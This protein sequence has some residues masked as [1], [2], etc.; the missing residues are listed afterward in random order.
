MAKTGT[1]TGGLDLSFVQDPNYESTN[2]K[3]THQ[4]KQAI[5]ARNALRLLMGGWPSSINPFLSSEVFSAVFILRNPNLLKEFRLAF[6]QGF[7]FLHQQLQNNPPLTADQQEQVQLYLS[8]CLSLLPY[9]DLTPWETIAMPQWIDGHWDLVLYQVEPIELTSQ[10]NPQGFFFKVLD[11]V[12]PWAKRFFTKDQDRVFAYG[13]KP[14]INTKAQ[15]HLIFMGTTYPVGQGFIRHIDT[16]LKG[17]ES[18][19]TSLYQQSRKRISHW[20]SQQNGKVHVCG[21]SLGGALSLLLAIDQ[22]EHIE[23][24]D[25]LNPPGLHDTWYKNSLDKWDTIEDKPKVVV[26]KQ[27]A[28]PVS[29]FGIWKKEWTVLAVQ[30]PKSK[31]GPNGF[32]DHALNYAGFANTQFTYVNAAD[33]NAKRGSR[34]FWIFSLGRALVYYTII[35]PYLY[36]IRPILYFHYEHRGSFALGIVAV[37]LITIALG[38]FSGGM[39][40]AS[41]ILGYALGLV[42]ESIYHAWSRFGRKHDETV[43]ALTPAEV[44][45]ITTLHHPEQPRNEEMDVYQSANE[46]EIELTTEQIQSYYKTMRTLK[47]KDYL[48]KHDQPSKHVIGYNKKDLLQQIEDK[49]LNGTIRFK[50]TPAKVMH[51]V[52]TLGFVAQIGNAARAKEQAPQEDVI[53]SLKHYRLGKH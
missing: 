1:F 40:P 43:G 52:Q 31:Q 33:D 29:F 9:A 24:V 32:V 50:A 38:A 25:A 13:L 30:P 45:S 26:Q 36:L 14:I 37:V 3:H 17:L 39:I 8:N 22:G 7:T 44:E 18:V 48:P 12:F 28:D 5:I 19:G 34:N 49:T 10:S 41:L 46:V 4:E 6:Q 16:D 53:N 11:G 15:S 27:G 20:L 2:S 21:M 35:A 23:R 42:G 47:G 51:I